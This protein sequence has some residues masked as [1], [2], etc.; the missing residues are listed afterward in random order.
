MSPKPGFIQLAPQ[1]DFPANC[2][3]C[4]TI[5]KAIGWKVPGLWTLAELKCDKCGLVFLEDL[6]YSLGV[7]TPFVLNTAT[8]KATPRY[9]GLW[10]ANVAAEA[11]E[12]RV[13]V[14]VSIKVVRNPKGKQACLVN[15]LYPWWGDAVS[16]LFR[17]NQIKQHSD[18]EI[19]VLINAGLLW[20]VPDHVG[21]VWIVEQGCPKTTNGTTG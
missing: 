5:A 1:T 20:L 11:W 15:C 21:G 2:P 12:E 7:T 9:S 18:I 8:G 16:L 19:I 6:P 3:S 14:D 13:P 17:V 10:Y 4:G